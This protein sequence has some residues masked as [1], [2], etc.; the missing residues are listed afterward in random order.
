MKRLF[1][2]PILEFT[3]LDTALFTE[4]KLRLLVAR[5]D[6]IHPIVSGNKL[7]KLHFFLEKATQSGYKSIL[8]FGGAWSNHLVAT[9]YSCK[10]AGLNSIGIVRG[11]EGDIASHTLKECIS[12][13]MQLQ[14]ISR[15]AYKKK[16]EIHFQNE[17][18]KTHGSCL[19]IPEG[20]YSSIGAQ[21]ASLIMDMLHDVHATHI[22][23][24]AGTATTLAGLMRNRLNNETIVAI[25]VLKNMTDIVE[26]ISFLNEKKET[27]N[28]VIFDQ[29]HFGGYAKKTNALISF[30]NELYTNYH[31]PTDFVYTAKMMYAITDKIKAG[32]FTGG[33]TI[34]CLHTGGLQGNSSL[35]A[36]TLVF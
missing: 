16:E 12:Y 21:G 24:A 35:S 19:I 4:K 31:L 11:E 29:Y 6:K 13:G 3:E 27:N 20:G 8:T 2:V 34:V 25:P 33:S 9:A 26:R 32:Y 18:Y 7:F 14:F 5:L 10:M 15:E 23:T 1:E 30:M 17:L 36:G 22:C 28:L